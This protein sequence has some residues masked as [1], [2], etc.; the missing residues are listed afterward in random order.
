MH[1]EL[2]PARHAAIAESTPRQLAWRWFKTF[3]WHLL[4]LFLS[5]FGRSLIRRKY[6]AVTTDRAY[7]VK[8]S[9]RFLVGKLIDWFVLRQSLHEGLRQRLR[10]VAS[11]LVR[12]TL[13]YENRGAVPVRIV[14]GPCGLGRD[15][16][17]TAQTLRAGGPLKG[18]VELWGIDL[19]SSGEALPEAAQRV[20]EQGVELAVRKSDLLAPSALM[21][22]F[23]GKRVHIF[24]SIGLTPWLTMEEVAR[25]FAT[26]HRILAP[27]G[28]LVVDNFHVHAQSKFGPDLEMDTRYHPDDLFERVLEAA[29]FEIEQRQET[30]NRVNVVYTARRR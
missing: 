2:S 29:G 1:I 24:N 11:E 30:P 26:A 22:E 23:Q 21:D 6:D 10:I 8:S 5:D 9:G 14:S 16:S 25:L 3:R 20:R 12:L 18:R 17:L 28:A 19:D 7:D 13:E 4:P 15:L 27:G